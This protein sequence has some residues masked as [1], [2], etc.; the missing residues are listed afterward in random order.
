[1]L[2]AAASAGN[3]VNAAERSFA[4]LRMTDIS[5]TDGIKDAGE[6]K[7]IVSAPMLQNYAETSV[8]VAFAVSDLANGY[9]LIGE[10]PDLSDARKVKC[11]GYRLTEISD[12]ANLC[13]T[14]SELDTFIE[15][16][17]ANRRPIPVSSIREEHFVDYPYWATRELL[18]NAICHRDYTS[19][20]P[21]QFYQY[22]DRI[23]IMNHGGLFGR[24]TEE[25][26]PQVNDYRN[27]VVAEAMK[28]LGFVNRHSRGVLKLQKDLLA[29]ENGKAI[30]N[31][32]CKTTVIVTVNKSHRGEHAIDDAIAQGFVTKNDYNQ[33]HTSTQLSENN[34][35]TTKLSISDKNP[36]QKQTY[37]ADFNFPTIIVKNVYE[38]I[39]LNKKVKTSWLANNFG[40]SDRTIQ[41]A[42]KKLQELGYINQEHS[43]LKGEWQILK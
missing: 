16:T 26:F 37:L 35:G 41:R 17:I 21:I 40:V 36:T 18:L 30:Y 42:V 34:Q 14:L 4:S 39:K 28:V 8:S 6:G 2:V 29:N 3:A 1:M 23:E 25:N 43:K 15:T 7:L 12:K 22:D 27:I 9:V 33:L 24:A 32:S 13:T 31:F 20:G 19:N 5:K 38:A 11:G 10:K